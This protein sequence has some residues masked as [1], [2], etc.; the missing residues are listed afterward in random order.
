MACTRDGIFNCGG[1]SA[2]FAATFIIIAF[3]A[4]S[5]ADRTC[6]GVTVC[7]SNGNGSLYYGSVDTHCTV[8]PNTEYYCEWREGAECPVTYSCS[9][10]GRYRDRRNA[11]II[12]IIGVLMA[13]VSV[14]CCVYGRGVDP[15]SPTRLDDAAHA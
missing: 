5:F 1:L 3:M 13:A 7:T 15:N 11:L 9:D 6:S 8:R 10:T 14:S 4:S 2:L 12:L